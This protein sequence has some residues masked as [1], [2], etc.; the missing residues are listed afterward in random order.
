MISKINLKRLIL[1]NDPFSVAMTNVNCMV[2]QPPQHSHL[3]YHKS[4]KI[5]ENKQDVIKENE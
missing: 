2:S 1:Q 5:N 4:H 3:G